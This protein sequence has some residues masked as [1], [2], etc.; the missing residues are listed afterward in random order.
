MIALPIIAWLLFADNS[1]QKIV[2]EPA[3][4][5]QA[6]PAELG[7]KKPPI[8]LPQSDQNIHT[9]SEPAEL[10][11]SSVKPEPRVS[12]IE[13]WREE[14][15]SSGS[16]EDLLVL[17]S[18]EGDE[19]LREQL[20]FEALMLDPQNTL[21]NFMVIEHCLAKPNSTHCGPHVFDV[22]AEMDGNNGLVRDFKA[23]QA[24]RDGDVDAALVSL[25]ESLSTK[26]ADDYQW[27]HISA[28]GDALTERGA[29]RDG[30]FIEEVLSATSARKSERMSEMMRMCQEQ[31]SNSLWRDICFG[32]GLALSRTGLSM[33]TQMLGHSMVVHSSAGSED[34]RKHYMNQM[35][36]KSNEYHSLS[37]SLSDR[38]VNNENWKLS[39]QQWQEYL[40]T[41][42]ERGEMEAL[43]YLIHAAD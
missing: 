4:A 23:V 24:Y 19:D 43:K 29:E 26:V 2:T 25:G 5:E 12:L 40:S 20:L 21:V 1:V 36:G 31:M 15:L 9:K 14:M 42:S 27:Q 7:Q 10:Q 11:Q 37:N 13:Q 41:Y 22:L 32:R 17:A 33:T 16:A 35:L 6:K 3:T 30:K 38:V 18:L 34:L 8:A 28:V 39:D